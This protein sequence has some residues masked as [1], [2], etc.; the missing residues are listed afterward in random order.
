MK[1]QEESYHRAMEQLV[2]GDKR[3]YEPNAPSRQ[4][5]PTLTVD[6]EPSYSADNHEIY[7]EAT[8]PAG[9]GPYSLIFKLADKRVMHAYG[10]YEDQQAPSYVNDI[11]FP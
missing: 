8:G 3:Q 10:S 7:L 5:Y 4:D 1:G 6:G 9:G 2:C 11:Q